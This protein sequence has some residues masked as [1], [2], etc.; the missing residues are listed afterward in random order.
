MNQTEKKKMR[1][2]YKDLQW[3]AFE[4]SLPMAR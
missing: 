4:S 3:Q 2:H 1:Q